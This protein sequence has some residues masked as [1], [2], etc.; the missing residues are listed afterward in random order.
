MTSPDESRVSVL[1][2]PVTMIEPSSASTTLRKGAKKGRR[3]TVR[4][5]CAAP[6][7]TMA[8][9][10]QF[11]GSATK[12]NHRATARNRGPTDAQ[13]SRKGSRATAQPSPYR[14]T[15]RLRTP[16]SGERE[17]GRRDRETPVAADLAGAGHPWRAARHIKEA[18]DVRFT[19]LGSSLRE[20]R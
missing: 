7:A 6:S 20:D 17:K 18:N 1:A 8:Q 16:R 2:M 4:H 9:P 13:P 3:L 19:T 12:R 10:S 14:G 15:V 5:G 11:A